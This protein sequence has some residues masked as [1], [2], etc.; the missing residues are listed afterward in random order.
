MQDI[1]EVFG[2]AL[3][4]KVFPND[5]ETKIYEQLVARIKF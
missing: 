5:W 1:L 4:K 3:G 2:G